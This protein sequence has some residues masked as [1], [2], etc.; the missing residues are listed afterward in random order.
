MINKGNM[1]I[2]SL[3][4]KISK[5]F[6]SVYKH[7]HVRGFRFGSMYPQQHDQERDIE[8]FH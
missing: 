5:I 7:T 6:V 8:F 2:L 3:Y 1:F 4:S